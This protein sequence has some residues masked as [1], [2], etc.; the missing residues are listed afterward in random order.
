[1]RA[2]AGWLLLAAALLLFLFLGDAPERTILWD[3]LFD[4]GHVPL[5]GLLAVA[6]LRV[7]RVRRPLTAPRT[8][9]RHAF[10]LTVA[11]G[12]ATELI[13]FFQANREPSLDDLA[14]DAAG[15]ASFLLAAAVWPWVGG[16][17]TPIST[18]RGR[19]RA[20]LLAG[21]LVAIAA[22]PLITAVAVVAARA[23]AMPT[24]ASF[25]GSW[26]ERRLIKPTNTLLTPGSRA[27]RYEGRFTRV[28]LQPGMYPGITIEEPYPDWRGYRRLA[29]TVVSDLD[30]PVR[31]AIRVHD[32]GHD[33]RTQD[34]F[35]RALPIS[36]GENHFAIPLD[37][38]RTAPDRREMD[39]SRV[40]GI[41]IFGYRLASPVHLFISP[42]RL[43]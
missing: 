41:I 6:A 12:A 31:L 28:D 5:F 1:M 9:W 22:V 10:F 23:H 34:R 16:G 35:N 40:R 42:L 4:M 32:A 3:A 20:G 19:V 13:Q 11:I 38:I 39:L 43:E 27:D 2:A 14:R 33:N 36:P 25:D 29:F 7:L 21:G 18:H 8:V 37:D 26:W 15:A 17:A 30:A 24:L